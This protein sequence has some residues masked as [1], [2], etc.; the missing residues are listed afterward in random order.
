MG[1]GMLRWGLS[2][3]VVVFQVAIRTNCR[4]EKID[5]ESCKVSLRDVN[6]EAV[7]DMAYDVCVLCTGSYPLCPLWRT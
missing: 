2:S 6:T 5:R 3:Y 4:A 1:C 7:E